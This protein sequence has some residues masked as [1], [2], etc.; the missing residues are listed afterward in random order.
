MNMD[1][2]R[3][4]HLV[5]DLAR[6]LAAKAAEAGLTNPQAHDPNT[7]V[8]KELHHL[9]VRRKVCTRV[10]FSAVTVTTGG[11]PL[12]GSEVADAFRA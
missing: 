10:A 2:Q 12:T 1:G 9:K 7:N 11:L 3:N 5:L 8:Q 4:S 6:E